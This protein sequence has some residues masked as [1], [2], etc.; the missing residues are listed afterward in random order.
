VGSWTP[1]SES[2]GSPGSRLR[3]ATRKE[4]EPE[5]TR[6]GRRRTCQRGNGLSSDTVWASML[7]LTPPHAEHDTREDVAPAAHDARRSR[8]CCRRDAAWVASTRN[9]A[10]PGIS[11]RR[12][13]SSKRGSRPTGYPAIQLAVQHRD[14]WRGACQTPSGFFGPRPAGQVC[15]NTGDERRVNDPRV[16]AETHLLQPVRKRPR[17]L[18]GRLKQGGD[19]AVR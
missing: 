15:E 19:V 7:T 5:Q 12:R 6:H 10:L 8:R 13:R 2:I 17:L 11:R 18:V 14:D 16:L 3:R 1:Q 9:T 4:Q